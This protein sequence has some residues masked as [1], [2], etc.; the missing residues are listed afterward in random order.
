MK[1]FDWVAVDALADYNRGE[2]IVMANSLEEALEIVKKENPEVYE[3]I[4][5]EEPDVYDS[6][7]AIYIYGSA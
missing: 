6:P 2:V 5:N 4:K 7:T 3:E 1:L